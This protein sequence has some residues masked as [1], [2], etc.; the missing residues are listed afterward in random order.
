MAGS[1]APHLTAVPCRHGIGAHA[2]VC[3]T[4]PPPEYEL[5]ASTP[6]VD[7]KS[8]GT[9]TDWGM[10]G[11]SVLESVLLMGSG[12]FGWSLLMDRWIGSKIIPGT[13]FPLH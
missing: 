5:R 13:L 8:S 9:P 1:I 4:P 6:A 12:V 11:W 10:R 7:A 2:I 3:P